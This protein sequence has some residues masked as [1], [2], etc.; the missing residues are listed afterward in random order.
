MA[1]DRYTRVL[2][3]VIA[4]C[5][6]Y[7]CVA[8]ARIGVPLA[9]QATTT[10]QQPAPITPGQQTGVAPVVVVGWKVPET[11]PIPVT[12]RGTVVTEQA[13]GTEGRVVVTGW[14]ES[15]RPAKVVLVGTDSDVS[16]SWRYSVPVGNDQRRLPPPR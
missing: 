15:G 3:T 1:A 14:Q 6:V 12:V 9:A 8:S 13:R 10:G 11:E 7:L 2:L 4:G 5:L 16:A